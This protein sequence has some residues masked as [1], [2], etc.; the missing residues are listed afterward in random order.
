MVYEHDILVPANTP[1]SA[2]VKLDISLTR[3]VIHKYEVFFPPGCA[4]LVK[5]SLNQAI[6]QVWPSNPDGKH[7]ADGTTLS[8]REHFPI[9]TEPY[10][11]TVTASSPGSNYAHT[12]T[13]RLALLSR[14]VLT[15]WL[16]SWAEKLGLYSGGE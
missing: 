14:R 11:I 3:G 10:L 15:P 13:V 5:V 7:K 12:I 9:D 4:N 8:F 2:P 6:H 16:L 1:D